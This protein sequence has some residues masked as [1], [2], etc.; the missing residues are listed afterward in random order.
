MVIDMKIAIVDDEAKEQEIIA[1]YIGEWAQAEKELVEFVRFDS[2]ES[3]LFSWED[4]KDYALLVLD[5][6]MGEISGLELAKKIRFEDKKIP[7]IFVTGYEEYIQYGYDVSA[8]HYL[9][10]PVNK[11]KLFQALGKLSEQEETV[12]SLILNAE[13]E[14][15]RIQMNQVLY[16]EAAGHGSIMHT[17]DEVIRLKASFG[18][19]EKQVLPM[20]EA[21]KCHRAYLVNLRFVSAIQNAN[22]IL[23]NGEKLPI[24]RSRMKHMQH[25]FLRYYRNGQG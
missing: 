3:F 25:E 8:L 19:I 14:V 22:L 20:G 17:V 18:E 5:I 23:D 16:V 13:N 4:A 7:I 6:E 10:K 11:E 21:V 24:A 12:R 15:R 9:I 2:S 1:K